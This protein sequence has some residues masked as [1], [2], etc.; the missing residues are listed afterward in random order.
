MWYKEKWSA[1]P[2]LVELSNKMKHEKSACISNTSLTG[3]S[4]KK[5]FFQWS[6]EAGDKVKR[7]E[8]WEKE[9]KK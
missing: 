8:E 1:L 2:S 4:I 9:V 6:K 3:R 7:I 5:S